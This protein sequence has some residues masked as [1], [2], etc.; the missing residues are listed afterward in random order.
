[1]NGLTDADGI[2]PDS[3]APLGRGV[4]PTTVFS[5]HHV[6]R[7]ALEFHERSRSV[8]ERRLTAVFRSRQRT[9]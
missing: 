5:S 4:A 8:G 3:P 2:A 7:I 6:A 1:M 9:T